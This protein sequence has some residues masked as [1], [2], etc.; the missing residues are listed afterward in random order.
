MESPARSYLKNKFKV[1]ASEMKMLRKDLK[2]QSIMDGMKKFRQYQSPV[3]HLVDT[4]NPTQAL[5]YKVDR[6]PG[7]Q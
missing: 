3:A 5:E 7:K 4:H 1:K 6:R 2:L